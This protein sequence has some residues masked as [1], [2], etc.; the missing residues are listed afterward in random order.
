MRENELYMASVQQEKSEESESSESSEKSES[1]DGKSSESSTEKSTEVV[2]MIRNK[3]TGEDELFRVLLDSG[4]NKSLGTYTAVKRA[5]LKI[6]SGKLQR[7]R[8]A[9]GTFDTHQES[10]IRRHRLMELSSHRELHHTNI[11]VT[12]SLGSYDFIFGRQYMLHYGIDLCFSRE[13]IEWDGISTPMKEPGYW[14]PE[15]LQVKAVQ[16]MDEIGEPS[17]NCAITAEQ[18]ESFA[19]QILDA[20]YEKQDL[21]T[22]VRELKHLTET[23]QQQM[24]NLLQ[25]HEELFSGQ[26]GRWRNLK[27]EATIKP[28][29]T[30]FHCQKPIRIPHIHVETLRKEVDRLVEIGVLAP[31]SGE[32]SGPWCAPSF[33]I[34]KKDGSVRLITDFRQ[35]NKAIERRPW[36]MPHIADLIQDIGRYSHVT[37]LDLSM[38]YYHFELSEELSNLCTFMLPFG[39]YKYKRLP[40]GLNISPDFFQ[41][42]MSEL[43]G[44][45]PFVK[46]YLD[47]L[48]IFSN[49]TYSDHLSKL[50][51]VLHRLRE[52]G[53]QVNA[54]K[55]FWAVKEVDY[56]G[57]RLTQDGVRPQPKKV[58]AIVNLEAPKTKRQ[59]RAFI[60][61][62]NY[63]RYMWR[64]RSHLLSPLTAMT[65]AQSKF[66]WTNECQQA[67]ETIKAV[68]QKEVMLAFP[69][70][71]KPFQIF[72]D[73]S[74]RQLGAIL[75]Q[76]ER[77][78]A[79]FSKKLNKAQKNYSPGE[80]EMLSIVEALR[81]FRTII[82][83]YPITIFT[84]H[85]NWV[86]DKKAITN[87]RVQRWRW[88]IEEFAP[89]LQYIEGAKNVVADALSRLPFTTPEISETD[90]VVVET[91]HVAKPPDRFYIPITFKRIAKEQEKDP[92]IKRMKAETPERL[93]ELVD[94][95]GKRDGPEKVIT[96]LS[97]TDHRE[98]VLVP[99]ETRQ[100]LL[101]WYHTMLVHPGE[102]RLFNTLHQHYTWPE[103]HSDIKKYLKTCD[104][105]QRGKRGMRGVG[106]VPLK[107]VEREPWKDIA[108]DLAGPWK[109]H[110]DKKEVLFHTLTI[111]D[112]F[113]SW[114]EIIP[115]MN[116]K[117]EHIRDL[118]EQEWL[119]RY[120]RPSRVIFDQG[121]EFDNQ[122]FY[123]LL[124]KWH[125]NPAMISVKN[126][127]ANAIVERLHKIMGDMLRVQLATE[128]KGDDPIK[129]MLSSAAFGVRATVHGT[130]MYTPAQL[131]FGRDM[132]L[133]AGMEADL[134]LVRQ[135][136][137]AAATKNNEKENKRRIAYNYQPGDKVLILTTGLDPKLKLHEGPFPVVRF[138]KANGILHIRR[139]NYEEPIHIRRVRPYFGSIREATDLTPVAAMDSKVKGPT[140]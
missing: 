68:I 118:V 62:V 25:E 86:H 124:K 111:I 59:L 61:M 55:S 97:P 65:S 42:R 96:I 131:I 18:E 95:I 21:K 4:T 70:Y 28:N 136:R 110:V 32:T 57:F 45:L 58:N 10:N 138:N 27:V 120:P 127:Q 121:G 39:M 56:L 7:Y 49:G 109:A 72:T 77:T 52:K 94:D 125:I 82:L 91:F 17:V 46:C 9:A 37:A 67:F 137:I 5:G 75:Q 83:G 26:L 78:L 51:Q 129:D 71:T 81:D 48:L 36:P 73:A 44:D 31:I 29:S 13:T 2:V 104:A 128:Y 76:D 140:V 20:K 64:R 1:E 11:H 84:D 132:I 133:R 134:E 107:D 8:T 24:K 85:K 66:I 99:K 92:W 89:Q 114:V 90:K 50:R 19:Q 100:P 116:K 93:S 112:P 54:T 122:W 33:I 63:Y 30:P 23:E 43:F 22:I 135:R 80:K 35:L 108:V 6:K 117:S 14:T 15:R 105:C 139:K 40:M 16:L 101:E 126:P 88:I 103:M 12:D 69:D 119:R 115:V 87:A 98:R 41:Q 130:T 60:G 53:L 102:T 34:P 47:D 113:T 123:T 79:F 74:D 106:K 38:G 3:G